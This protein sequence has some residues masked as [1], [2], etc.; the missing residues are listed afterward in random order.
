MLKILQS[1]LD[2]I[3]ALPSQYPEED[4]PEIACAGRSNVGKSSF[5]NSVLGRKN[6]ARTSS[7]PGKTRTLNFYRVNED[8]RFVDLPGYGYAAVSKSEKAKWGEIIEAYLSS[9]KNLREVLLIVDIRHKPTEQDIQ[10]YDW[11]RS[12]GYKGIVIASK[13]DKISRGRHAKALS[14]IAKTLHVEDMSTIIPYSS[15]TKWN[16]ERILEKMEQILL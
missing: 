13:A 12:Y 10:M 8:F 5:I 4:M 16:L 15:V 11:I 14:E 6:L 9:R 7:K 3:A 1:N 2:T